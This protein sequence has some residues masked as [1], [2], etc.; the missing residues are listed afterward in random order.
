MLARRTRSFFFASLLGL[1]GCGQAHEHDPA[2]TIAAASPTAAPISA[3]VSAS[4]V[5]PAKATGASE[6]DDSMPTETFT[7]GKRAFATL[8]KALLDEYYAAG[9]TE[10]D[11]YRAAARG[12]LERVDPKMKKWNK[13]LPPSELAFMRTDLKGEVVG[14]GVQ[15]KFESDTGWSDVLGVV[16]GSP[17]EKAGIA[18]GDKIVSVN[19]KLYKGMSTREIVAD[20]RGKAGETVTLTI[21]RGDKLVPFPIKREVV[22][23]DAVSSLLLENGVGYALVHAFTEKTVATLRAALDDLGKKGARALVLDLRHNQGGLFD[24]AVATAGLFV[25]E[26]TAIVKLK[27]RGDKEEMLTAKGATSAATIPIAILV[28]HETSSGAELVTG[29]LQEGRH[30]P[31]VGARTTGKWSVQVIKELGNGYAA[32]FT[33]TLFQT[34]S[35]K[36]FDG[37][38]LLPDVEVGMDEMQC[39]KAQLITD[40]DKRLAA[41]PQLRTAVA[42]LRAKL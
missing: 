10:D 3:T 20:I 35:G 24:E 1:L 41:D 32:K 8:E 14:V 30:A 9:F 5:T 15:I 27:K 38:G 19:G 18:G 2:P 31:V 22:T 42:I 36:S 13:L 4:P 7:D 11:M 29:A 34:P 40:P 17:A 6:D 23:Y 39:A 33:T 25:P 26:G 16:P 12:M 28:D 21:L 37:V